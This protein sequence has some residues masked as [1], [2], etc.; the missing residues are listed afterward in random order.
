MLTTAGHPETWADGIQLPQGA[1]LSVPQTSNDITILTVDDE[2]ES[3]NVLFNQLSD[4]GYTMLTAESGKLALEIVERNL[5]ISLVIL[6]VVMPEMGGLETLQKLKH[7]N[8]LK[9]D[10]DVIMLSDLADSEIVR[11]AFSLGASDFLLKP[12]DTE[13]IE[14]SIIAC[15]ARTAFRK[16]SW[17]KRLAAKQT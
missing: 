3:L 11:R 4:H 9:R 16:R 5:S 10:L 7:L 17:W 2:V 15:L 13:L 1:W 8:N 14:N 12:I 6:D